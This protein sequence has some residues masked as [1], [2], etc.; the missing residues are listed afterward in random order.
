MGITY[1][2][3]ASFV[4]Y[5]EPAAQRDVDRHRDESPGFYTVDA[6][7][8]DT[9]GLSARAS[10]AFHWSG[11]GG[12]AADTSGD[13]DCADIGEEV[14]VGDDDPYNLDGDGDGYGCDGW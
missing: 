9:T 10:C 13:L 3:G 8:T 2:D 1:G 12:S 4:A 5:D 6:W 14:W 7:V 11:S